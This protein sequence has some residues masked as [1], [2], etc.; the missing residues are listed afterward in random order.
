M[1]PKKD[2]NVGGGKPVEEGKDMASPAFHLVSP[3]GLSTSRKESNPLAK[4]SDEELFALIKNDDRDAFRV[5]MERYEGRAVHTARSIVLNMETA[6]EVA[7]DVFLKIY[8]HRDR[9]DL[10]RRFSTWFYRILRN[11]AVDLARRQAS[12]TPG[13]AMGLVGDWDGRELGPARSASR[14]E[15]KGQVLSVLNALPAKFRM[16][17]TLRELEGLGCSE[18]G[19]RVGA[20]AGT[21]RWRLHHA[22]KL[23]RAQWERTLGPDLGGGE[24]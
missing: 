7:Q 12:G 2:P 23:F 20:K 4:L 13:A 14:E 15:R 22:R 6:R 8:A 9:F 10:K 3:S 19:E 16:V 24:L 11:R 5:L 1:K 18:I 21:V 17:L